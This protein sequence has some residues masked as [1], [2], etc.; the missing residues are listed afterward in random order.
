MY[1]APAAG[2]IGAIGAIAYYYSIIIIYLHNVCYN[3]SNSI[4]KYFYFYK[5]ITNTYGKVG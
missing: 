1:R 2:A 4:H 5:Q 3:N